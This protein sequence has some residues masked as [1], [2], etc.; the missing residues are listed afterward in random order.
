M[1]G[2]EAAAGAGRGQSGRWGGGGRAAERQDEAGTR[3][4]G[5]G[6]GAV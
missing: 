1:S 6:A 4:W 5:E 2:G 3:R